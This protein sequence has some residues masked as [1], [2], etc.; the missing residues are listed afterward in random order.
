MMTALCFF[1][2]FFIFFYF[3]KLGDDDSERRKIYFQLYLRL[4]F[5]INTSTSR[6]YVMS[7]GVSPLFIN[8]KISKL[9]FVI[10]T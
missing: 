5:I 4:L 3:P 1:H 6:H 10:S 7:L 2:I 8:F 9:C